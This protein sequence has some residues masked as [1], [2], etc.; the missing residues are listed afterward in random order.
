MR[1]RRDMI[2]F[3]WIWL[4]FVTI[5]QHSLCFAADLP[6]AEKILGSGDTRRRPDYDQALIDQAEAY[7]SNKEYSMAERVLLGLVESRDITK[8]REVLYGLGRVYYYLNNFGK[9]KE[10]LT[11]ALALDE[12]LDFSKET[13]LTQTMAGIHV[14]LAYVYM[15][16]GAHEQAIKVLVNAEK[17]GLAEVIRTQF[18]GP[19]IYSL[20]AK[21]CLNIGDVT[22]AKEYFARSNAL[23]ITDA[24][25]AF[26]IKQ[27]SLLGLGSCNI[28]LQEYAAA[29]PVFKE[30]IERNKENKND[31]FKIAAYIGLSNA[32][33]FNGEYEK[34]YQECVD[35][36]ESLSAGLKKIEA[37]YISG[38]IQLKRN[39]V[40]DAEGY[41]KRMLQNIKSQGGAAIN[42]NFSVNWGLL[43]SLAH[44]NLGLVALQ[45]KQFQDAAD[46]MN[47]AAAVLRGIS[48]PVMK[49]KDSV[50]YLKIACQYGIFKSL[51]N[52]NKNEAAKES[53]EFLVQM[54]KN[55]GV[56]EREILDSKRFP[57]YID[58]PSIAEMLKG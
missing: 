3:V 6:G 29:I 14:Y 53:F 16:G 20:I 46:E 49:K 13:R 58:G 30:A 37:D 24:S 34:A 17:S 31:D 4:L 47:A 25:V 50:I 8:K 28:I 51:K 10:Y 55:L 23:E 41:F 32:Y 44:Y 56:K 18:L 27:I 15:Q 40:K 2:F 1:H 33:V 57:M 36:L 7:I 5:S 39:K 52:Q 19:N 54:I 11:V 35:T 22:L 9:A 12:G 38:V 21:N 45:E 42:A 48:S 26:R 43:E